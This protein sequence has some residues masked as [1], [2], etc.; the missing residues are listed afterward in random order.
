MKGVAYGI[1]VGPG[2]PELMTLKAVRIIRAC[3]VVAVPGD[4]PQHSRAYRIAVAAVPEL[5]RKKLVPL[6][7]P[8]TRNHAQVEASAHKNARLL[9][10]YLDVGANVACLTLGDPTLYSTFTYLRRALEADGYRAEYVSGVPSFCAAAARLGVSLAEGDEALRVVP[11]DPE[12][13]DSPLAGTHVILKGGMRAREIAELLAR[14]GHEVYAVEN[15]GMDD[16]HV[17]RGLEEIPDRLGYLSLLI[18]R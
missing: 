12:T 16:E 6:S 17:Y 15:C 9:K 14:D 5:S 4:N 18:A 10:E 3:D 11:G 7:A 1:G 13:K 8:M 2:D